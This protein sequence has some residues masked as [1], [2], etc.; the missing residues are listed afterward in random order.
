MFRHLPILALTLVLTG[1]AT[2]APS[3]PENYSG[4][5]AQLDD[6]VKVYSGSKAD[7]FV[8]EEIDSMQVESSLNAT[9][10]A[11]QGRGASMSPVLV[12]RP[13]VAEKPLKISIKGRTQFAAPILAMTN[14]VYQVKGVVEFTPK[15]NGKYTVRGELGE[16]YS[17]IWVEDT[18]T[19]QPV[20]PKVEVNG[21]AALGFLEK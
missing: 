17:A 6:S 3:V 11:N 7:F 4:P 20:G 18:A 19:N 1:C 9:L 13:L 2:Y 5:R 16:K 14:T 21:S 10:R 8:V 12:G 15:A